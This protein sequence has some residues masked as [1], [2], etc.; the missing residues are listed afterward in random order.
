ML[1]LPANDGSKDNAQRSMMLET[2][3][4]ELCAKVAPKA[5]ARFSI[6]WSPRS[7]WP[8]MFGDSAWFAKFEYCSSQNED[9]KPS[10]TKME[11]VF[12]IEQTGIYDVSTCIREYRIKGT[13]DN[14][15]ICKVLECVVPE[16]FHRAIFELK[17]PE[18]HSY[19]TSPKVRGVIINWDGRRI[20]FNLHAESSPEDLRRMWDSI[21]EPW[22]ASLKLT[23]AAS[24][25]DKLLN[26]LDK[27]LEEFEIS[28][29]KAD[30]VKRISEVRSALWLFDQYMACDQ[31]GRFGVLREKSEAILP[32]PHMRDEEPSGQDSP[33]GRI[34]LVINFQDDRLPPMAE[35]LR[36]RAPR[37]KM[38]P[39]AAIRE[40]DEDE[41]CAESSTTTK[42][43]EPTAPPSACCV[44]DDVD[45]KCGE[46][47]EAAPAEES[48]RDFTPQTL[49]SG[50]DISILRMVDRE[51]KF[52][53]NRPIWR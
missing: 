47:G 10:S 36:Q 34:A 31:Q 14:Y 35:H 7:I 45:D 21:S 6:G 8:R 32:I 23:L 1:I 5:A 20:F 49:G 37:R 48:Q 51:A 53:R 38:V 40:A 33:P 17:K 46:R 39:K 16:P 44:S 13:T 3:I 9:R 52:N 30:I 41:D 12:K 24:K 25:L 18:T 43:E 28:I 4:T 22:E 26:K 27:L 15:F 50:Y 29:Y 42:K 2:L 11:L 19:E